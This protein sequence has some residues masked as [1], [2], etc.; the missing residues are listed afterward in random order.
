MATAKKTA[1]RPTVKRAPAKSTSTTRVTTRKATADE[2]EMRSFRRART[3]AFFTFRI[4][5]Q[6]FYWGIICAAVLA[7]GIWVLSINIQVQSLYDQIDAQ[8]QSILDMPN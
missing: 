8:N 3:E 6:T 2:L 7:L 4:T 5:R 1:K